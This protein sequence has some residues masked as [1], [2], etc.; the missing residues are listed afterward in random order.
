M[1][2]GSVAIAQAE[3]SAAEPPP[4][5]VKAPAATKPAESPPQPA[6][7]K[8]EGAPPKAAEAKPEGAPP[9][10][11]PVQSEPPR[12]GST[13]RTVGYVVECVG[14][15]GIIAGAVL[16]AMSSAK[17]DVINEH[18]DDKRICDQTG[19]D[20]VSQASK[21]QAI[22]F[23]SLIGGM[24]ALGTGIALVV[25]A[26]EGGGARASVGPAVLH[27]GAGLSVAGSF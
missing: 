4:S 11:K 25:S 2:F 20:A 21:L 12:K 19:M 22:A 10:A 7:A 15:A 8:P 5:A 27:G 18:C 17:Y 24:A 23:G 1:S 9:A 6:D 3:K 16:K 14:L 13:V 26:P